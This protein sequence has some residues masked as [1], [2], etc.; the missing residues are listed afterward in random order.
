MLNFP[1]IHQAVEHHASAI[2][3]HTAIDE[4][5]RSISYSELS[6]SMQQVASYLQ[7][8][9][10]NKNDRIGLLLDNGIEACI[11]I[12][13]TLRAGACYVPINTTFPTAR[14][15]FIVE[16]AEIKIVITTQKQLEKLVA[17]SKESNNLKLDSLIIIDANEKDI[18]SKEPVASLACFFKEIVG[19]ETL[20]KTSVPKPCSSAENDLA[21]I[22][23]TSGTTGTPKG[24]MIT[25]KNVTAFLNWAVE[26]YSLTAQDRMSNHSDISF[27]LSVFDIFGSFFSGATLCPITHAGDYAFPANFIKDR[28]LTIWF[29][30]PG[31]LGTLWKSG[32]LTEGAFSKHLRWAIFCGEALPPKYADLWIRTST[33]KPKD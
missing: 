26:Y 2:P 3:N 29:S 14:L 11:G 32:Q 4:G 10:I 31:V 19:Q 13:G 21:Y 33:E 5:D 17:L 9:N 24:V 12:L 7:K 22:M 16:D 25:H 20:Q 27:D 23:Y 28:N 18:Q 30:V 8:L 6:D 15:K 1:L